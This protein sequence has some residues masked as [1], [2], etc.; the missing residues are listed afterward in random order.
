MGSR[1]RDPMLVHHARIAQRRFL[2]DFALD[3]APQR[4]GHSWARARQA[5]KAGRVYFTGLLQPVHVKSMERIAVSGGIPAHRVRQFITRSPWDADRLLE[6]LLGRMRSLTSPQGVVIIDDTGQEKQ[7][8][9]SV[10]VGHQYSGTLG[11]L[12]NC[13]VAVTA[14]YVMPGEKRNADAVGW[15]LGMDLYLPKAWVEDPERRKEVGIPQD[16]LY[17]TKPEIALGMLERVRRQ[18]IPH[19]AV[20]MDAGYGDVDPFRRKLREQG[21]P[22]V[23]AWTTVHHRVLHAEAP[24]AA[25]VQ[26]LPKGVRIGQTPKEIAALTPDSHWKDVSWAEGTKQRL[27]RR[28]ARH[29][30]RVVHTVVNLHDRREITDEE[31]CLLLERDE[32]ELKAYFVSGLNDLSLEQQ[33]GLTHTRWAIEQY[34]RE[35]KQTLG[36]DRFEGRTW[37]GWHHHLAMICLAYAFLAQLRAEMG[38]RSLPP[39][40]AI[41][42]AVMFSLIRHEVLEDQ[43][44][45]SRQSHE[46]AYRFLVRV[47]GLRQPPE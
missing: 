12:G 20:I 37:R 13:Q 1:D 18:A 40:N 27:H 25:K 38:P 31:G 6:S 11:G 21:E 36:M 44:L 8:S 5:W 15:P 26:V 45:T 16:L 33:V 23:A 42:W 34:H 29:R 32:K 41:H 19:M 3:F 17:R 43:G 24:E 22:Y 46:I 28:F 7:G 30:V 10:G 35:I 9:H 2:Q 47:L 14:L 4:R 39:L